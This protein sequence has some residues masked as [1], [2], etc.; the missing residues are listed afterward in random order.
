MN[1][2]D[3]LQLEWQSRQ[4]NKQARQAEMDR[5]TREHQ[6]K[7]ARYR[8]HRETMKLAGPEPLNLHAIGDSWFEYPLDGNIPIPFYNSAIVADSQLV[9]KGN[10]RPLVLSRAWH[11][12]ASTAVL[13][14]ENQSTMVNDWIT[15]ANWPPT[16]KLDAILV[17]MGGDDIVGD[18][19][20]I[21]LTYGGGVKT[22]SG[23]L[24][25]VLDLVSA[26]YVDLFELR[27]LFAPDVP[28]FGHCYDYALPNGV[29]AAGVF[30]PWLQPSFN[31]AYYAYADALP[32]VADM[33]DKFNSMLS[34]LAAV[35]A[36]NFHLID[37]RKTIAPNNASPNGWAN[38]L[39]P[40]PTGFGLL[41]DKFLAALKVRF[42]G[43]I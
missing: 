31:F 34:G 41:A 2:A 11:G 43:R 38:E 20:A 6:L 16:G 10:P 21:Y 5:R 9:A 40:Y 35:A 42:P 18:Q 33:I 4:A 39:H 22:A 7:V 29:P 13:T 19:L 27:N 3:T 25:G 17:S 12:Q 37:T 32:I 15:A 8:T 36:N 1:G 28:I 26:S 30:G 14:W 24:Q 23:R